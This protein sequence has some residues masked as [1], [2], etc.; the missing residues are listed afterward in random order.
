MKYK[1]INRAQCFVILM[2]VLS[3]LLVASFVAFIVVP[4]NCHEVNEEAKPV[5]ITDPSVPGISGL[6]GV[7]G[8]P[9][10]LRVH[11][12]SMTFMSPDLEKKIFASDPDDIILSPTYPRFR[13]LPNGECIHIFRNG[14]MI[15]NGRLLTENGADLLEAY[16]QGQKDLE[17]V[18]TIS[19][20]Y[21]FSRN[22]DK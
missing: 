10:V 4:H 6:P 18:M 19:Y 22:D 17:S 2:S 12:V 3:V 9:K 11:G 14:D 5:V 1:S 7:L 21:G 13:H 8:F 15:Y 20:R 16:L